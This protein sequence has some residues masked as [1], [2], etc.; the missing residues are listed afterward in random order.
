MNRGLGRTIRKYFFVLAL[1]FWSSGSLWAQKATVVRTAGIACGVYLSQLSDPSKG[2]KIA[3][4]NDEKFVEWVAQNTTEINADKAQFYVVGL[5]LYGKERATNIEYVKDVLKR[6]GFEDVQVRP[7]TKP[8]GLIQ[9]LRAQFPIRE[10][11]QRPTAGELKQAAFWWTIGAGVFAAVQSYQ[12]LHGKFGDATWAL[13]TAIVV[14]NALQSASTTFPRQAFGNW[15]AL[16]SRSLGAGKWLWDRL[17]L[18]PLAQKAT[19]KFQAFALNAPVFLLDKVLLN[20]KMPK[21]FGLGYVFTMGISAAYAAYHGDYLFALMP[22]SWG[23]VLTTKW[24]SIVIPIIWRIPVEAGVPEWAASRNEQGQSE[25]I[26]RNWGTFY[27]QAASMTATPF[28]AY[29]TLSG[30]SYGRYMGVDWN[31]GHVGMGLVAVTAAT[32]WARPELYDVV[33]KLLGHFKKQ[34]SLE[35]SK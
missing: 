9:N 12:F 22:A 27:R 3:E 26:V 28:W 10:D 11:W 33:P 35:E 16:R 17:R 21:Q 5:P 1:I 7:I 29:A 8:K 32:A 25:K 4:L 13:P 14:V 34:K 15:F 2:V 6:A 24:A 31:F 23:A 20:E 19:N 30:D 18:T